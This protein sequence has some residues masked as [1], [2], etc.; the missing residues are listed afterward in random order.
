[1]HRG[2]VLAYPDSRIAKKMPR[3]SDE[4]V[5][6][7]Y[8]DWL[9]RPYSRINLYLSPIERKDIGESDSTASEV[10][11]IDWSELEH[12]INFDNISLSLPEMDNSAVPELMPLIPQQNEDTIPTADLSFVATDFL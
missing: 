8:K 10:E 3:T 2:Y 5:L 6:S 9:G 1:M 7:N 12:D 4:F 11:I